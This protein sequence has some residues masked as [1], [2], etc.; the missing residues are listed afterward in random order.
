MSQANS[1]IHSACLNGESGCLVAMLNRIEHVDNGKM[2]RLM[3]A[4]ANSDGYNPFH[5][6]S[7][8]LGDGECLEELVTFCKRFDK[9][10]ATSSEAGVEP[11][12]NL[13]IPGGPNAWTPLHLAAVYGR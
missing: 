8:T 3:L 12:L 11:T 5:L 1:P 13:E 4:S 7:L 2:L 10:H 9:V 6:A